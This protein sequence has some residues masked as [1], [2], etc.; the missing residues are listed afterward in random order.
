MFLSKILSIIFI[1]YLGYIQIRKGPN[2][3]GILGLLQPFR[4][5]IKL[6]TKKQIFPLISNYILYYFSPVVNLFFTLF[7]WICVPFLVE[8]P[9]L[10]GESELKARN[11]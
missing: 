7:I 8:D 4:V 2:K 5:A 6:F 9:L 3:L 10:Y 11:I 1:I